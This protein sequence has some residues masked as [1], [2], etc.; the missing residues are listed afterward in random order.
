MTKQTS[1]AESSVKI[2]WKKLINDLLKKYRQDLIV[3]GGGGEGE[4]I[5]LDRENWFAEQV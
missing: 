3:S 1:L 2:F 4:G 5:R